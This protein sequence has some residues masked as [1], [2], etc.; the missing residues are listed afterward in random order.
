MRIK[1]RLDQ[2]WDKSRES[3]RRMKGY[4]KNLM[5]S[6]QEK[7]SRGASVIVRLIPF[8]RKENWRH[9]DKR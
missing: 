2:W 8:A 7:L 6:T 5:A 1:Q 9:K 4:W 3:R